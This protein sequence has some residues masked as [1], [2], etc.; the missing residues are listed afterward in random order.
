MK[1]RI[2]FS[3][4]I[5][6]TCLLAQPILAQTGANSAGA[7]KAE[8]SDKAHKLNSQAIALHKEGKYEE[9]INLEKQAGKTGWKNRRLLSACGGRRRIAGSDRKSHRK[10]QE[11]L[12]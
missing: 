1:K 8:G 4:V 5:L 7:A 12:S 2:S 6:L 10:A 11:R 3:P 9:A